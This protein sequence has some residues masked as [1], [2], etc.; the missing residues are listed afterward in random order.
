M[1]HKFQSFGTKGRPHL[2]W[3]ADFYIF[4]IFAMAFG[5]NE[6]LTILSNDC[7]DF[8]LTCKNCRSKHNCW[9]HTSQEVPKK[10]GRQSNYLL[11]EASCISITEYVIQIWK[12]TMHTYCIDRDGWFKLSSL[13][14]KSDSQNECGREATVRV[15]QLKK[16]LFGSSPYENIVITVFKISPLIRSKKEP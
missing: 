4:E 9:A 14:S 15:C 1:S 5:G 8:I 6:E 12:E 3:V 13:L 11:T 7:A 16:S 10:G 2:F